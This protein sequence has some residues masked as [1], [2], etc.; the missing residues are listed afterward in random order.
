LISVAC[1]FSKEW[2]I[3]LPP[4]MEPHTIYDFKMY[5]TGLEGSHKR[6]QEK[7]EAGCIYGSVPKNAI[8]NC[9]SRSDKK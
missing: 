2:K 5:G 7:E 9:E 4:D 8:L 3:I 6:V 1:P